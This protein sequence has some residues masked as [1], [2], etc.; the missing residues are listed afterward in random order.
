MN[1]HSSCNLY[2]I[3]IIVVLVVDIF[4]D[5]WLYIDESV[6]ALAGGGGWTALNGHIEIMKMHC[7]RCI[8]YKRR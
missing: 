6:E 3:I 8:T 5:S 4:A 1:V 2:G 7:R